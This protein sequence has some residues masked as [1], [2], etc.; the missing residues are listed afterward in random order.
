MFG[1]LKSGFKK[2]QQALKKT[3]N[4]LGERIRGL[5]GKAI[6]EETFEQLEQI[7]FEADL[8]SELAVRF[9]DK[10]RKFWKSS[11]SPTVDSMLHHLKEEARSIL[12]KPSKESTTSGHPHVILLVGVNGSGKTTTA[13]K[14]ALK[15]KKN[16]KKVLLAAG[17]TF[18]AAAV[19]QLEKWSNRID[20]P[21]IKSQKG[22]DPAAVAFDAIVAGK[23]R[24]CDL[25]IAD[26]AGRL[27]SKTELMAELQKVVTVCNK[28]NPGSPHEIVLVLDAT[29]GQNALDQVEIFN[30][31]APLTGL[32]ITKLDG[33]AKGG[34]LLSIYDR[35]SLPIKY[36]GVGEGEEDLVPFDKDQYLDS[37]F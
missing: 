9:S 34:I 11:S 35:F 28:A 12:N 19:E 26:T 36:I 21:L 2:V 23:A 1:L 31:S 5:F 33:S 29:T 30:Q 4:A 24:G 10:L 20:V 32:V 3:K 27:E 25:I 7:L 22:S 8:G 17:D 13:A 14:I 16:G 18:R 15:E 37:L 6:D